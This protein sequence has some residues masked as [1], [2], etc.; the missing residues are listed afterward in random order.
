MGGRAGGRPAGFV[1]QAMQHLLDGFVS[2]AADHLYTLPAQLHEAEG[3][4]IEPSSTAGLVGPV[5]VV[6]DA[7]YRDRLGL[8]DETLARATHIAWA[9]GGSMVPRP[10]MGEYVRR[11]SGLL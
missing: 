6:E 11:G 9:T 2:V 1:G 7:E 5:R 10:E 8:D 4:D 3:I